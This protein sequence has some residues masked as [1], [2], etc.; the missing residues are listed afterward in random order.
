MPVQIT[1]DTW[2]VKTTL[3]PGYYDACCMGISNG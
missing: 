1:P 2:T 3:L